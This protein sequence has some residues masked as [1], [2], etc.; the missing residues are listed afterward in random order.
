ME[1][2]KTKPFWGSEKLGAF[3]FTYPIGKC[4]CDFNENQ[5]RG[6]QAHETKRQT[7]NS[8]RKEQSREAETK[9]QGGREEER[10][11]SPSVGRPNTGKEEEEMEHTC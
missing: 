1:P 4:S 3:N 11:E 8:D 7:G 2:S 6:R 10:P 5:A 9:V